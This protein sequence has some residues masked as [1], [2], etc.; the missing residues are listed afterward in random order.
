MRHG[1][2][3]RSLP[4]APQAFEACGCL[5]YTRLSLLACDPGVFA[6]PNC[7]SLCFRY[8]NP[9][10]LHRKGLQKAHYWQEC[11]PIRRIETY[12]EVVRIEGF[13]DRAKLDD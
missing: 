5:A 4:G 8:D 9:D 10:R 2:R 7:R 6:L 3:K 13:L 1:Y 12:K 11:C